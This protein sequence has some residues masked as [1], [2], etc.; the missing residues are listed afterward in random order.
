MEG[1]SS[2]A[3]CSGCPRCADLSKPGVL[4][5]NFLVEHLLSFQPDHCHKP[6]LLP[7]GTLGHQRIIKVEG[8]SEITESNPSCSMH[9]GGTSPGKPRAAHSPGKSLPPLAAE[10]AQSSSWPWRTA[11]RASPHS[12]HEQ[13]SETTSSPWDFSGGCLL[14]GG[15]L[16]FI[17]LIIL[18]RVLFPLRLQR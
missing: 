13:H 11:G 5:Q 12:T 15:S 18:C 4:T 16:P 8:I 3:K 9:R 7:A 1:L 17:S 6:Q 2:T 10:C 14:T